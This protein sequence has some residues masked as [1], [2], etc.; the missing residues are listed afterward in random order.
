MAT[1]T[2]LPP[3]PASPSSASPDADVP[4]GRV[5][6]ASRAELAGIERKEIAKA[7]EQCQNDASNDTKRQPLT[8]PGGGAGGGAQKKSPNVPELKIEQNNSGGS[9]SNGTD[10]VIGE[11]TRGALVPADCFRAGHPG[12]TPHAGALL[13]NGL[14]AHALETPTPKIPEL[15]RTPTTLLTSPT[16][17]CASGSKTSVD[18]EDSASG[19]F[20]Y[21]SN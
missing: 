1:V 21:L 17:I 10:C 2:A 18:G 7:R 5:T 9:N 13:S 6:E 4:D 11:T 16:N 14:L 15:L 19:V 12:G 3:T 8:S 20:S